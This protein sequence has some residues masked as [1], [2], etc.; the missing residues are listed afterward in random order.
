[1]KIKLFI[2]H[3]LK[4]Y[5]LSY[6]ENWDES[7]LLT[8][9]DNGQ[10]V[11]SCVICLDLT[12]DVIDQALR[13]HAQVIISHHPIFQKNPDYHPNQNEQMV[14]QRLHDNQIS[15]LCLH[16]CYDN[17]KKGMNA[18]LSNLLGFD[19]LTWFNNEIKSN[20]VLINLASA[21]SI[22]KIASLV[23]EKVKYCNCLITN[24]EE[25]EKL[26][27]SLAICAGA[28]YD[29]LAQSF[30]VKNMTN[31]LFITGDIKY[32]NW[33]TIQEHSL[34]FLDVGHEIENIF[35]DDIDHYLHEKFKDIKTTKI[36]SSIKKRVI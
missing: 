4:K 22:N 18:V 34:N 24:V 7:G 20:F 31:T 32:H 6:Q 8:F 29:V 2:N 26:F 17:N 12:N 5:P 1:M 11:T 14:I 28:G 13:Q 30:E 21:M 3:M 33:V 9:Y 27:S 35:V 10:H 19:T 16:T 15:W 25:D 23:K 36:Y